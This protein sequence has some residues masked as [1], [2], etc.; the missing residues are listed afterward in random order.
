[1]TKQEKQKHCQGCRN[2]FYNGN[3]H[4]KIKECWSLD[5]AGIVRRKEVSIHQ[6][7][8]WEQKAE[9]FLDCYRKKGYVYTHPERTH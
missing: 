1:M 9:R 4:Y 2:N 5:K 8:P 7:P 6:V 3:N